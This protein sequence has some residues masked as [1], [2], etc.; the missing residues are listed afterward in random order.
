MD[1]IRFL[2][3]GARLYFW[4]LVAVIV[5]AA[6][7]FVLRALIGVAVEQVAWIAL[8]SL[9]ALLVAFLA[10]IRRAMGN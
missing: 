7:W 9:L 4:L 3:K 10:A 8:V 6:S 2:Q 1:P 5:G